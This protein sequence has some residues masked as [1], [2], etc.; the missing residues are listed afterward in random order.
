MIALQAVLTVALIL[1]MRRSAAARMWQATAPAI[2][3]LLALAFAAITKARLL[4]PLLGAPV[5]GWRWPL[6][7]AAAA[8]IVVGQLVTRP[9]CPNGWSCLGIPRSCSRSASCLEARLHPEDRCCSGCARDCRRSSRRPG[10][11]APSGR[12]R[13]APA[14]ARVTAPSPWRRFAL[15][16]EVAHA[17]ED[18]RQAGLVGGGDHLVVA[19]RAARLDH[20]RGA[21]LDRRQQP[22][23]KGKKASD[24]TAEPIVRGS[25]QPAFLG[26]VARLPGG[27]A[28]DSRRF[29]CPAPMPA[30]APSL[31]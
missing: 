9:R 28:A 10:P 7:W 19:D 3:L 29:I 30:V 1:L 14:T 2:A 13:G 11:R 27:D 5:S 18:H 17:G 16:P 12:I 22:S 20:R 26:R 23:A 24:A 31:A 21:R 25:A 15:V 6:V 8:A 4:L